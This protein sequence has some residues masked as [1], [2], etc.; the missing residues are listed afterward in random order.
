MCISFTQEMFAFRFILRNGNSQTDSTWG[1]VSHRSEREISVHVNT[2]T[3]SCGRLLQKHS[4][5]VLF[6]HSPVHGETDASHSARPFPLSILTLHVYFRDLL[7]RFSSTVWR[8]FN[9]SQCTVEHGTLLG[10]GCF[11]KTMPRATKTGASRLYSVL[12][13]AA[14]CD[15]RH[16]HPR[17]APC[18]TSKRNQ[19]RVIVKKTLH[20]CLW[21]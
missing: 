17:G 16:A 4:L 21:K 6:P 15:H 1:K 10:C 7:A 11:L 3:T 18:S 14:G 20:N 9:R 2:C 8:I 5:C 19:G 12:R 13:G